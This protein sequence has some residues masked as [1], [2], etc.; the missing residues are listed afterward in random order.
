MTHRYLRAA[1]AASFVWFV[2]LSA[3]A[4]YEAITVDP[5][6]FLGENRGPMFFSWSP[7]LVFNDTSFGNF[8]LVFDAF[9]FWAAVLLPIAALI[10]FAITAQRLTH[11][12][13]RSRRYR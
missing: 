6:S 10:A 3:I 9:S 7:Y 4:A 8:V 11:S 5:W 1:I 2:L 13:R 12:V